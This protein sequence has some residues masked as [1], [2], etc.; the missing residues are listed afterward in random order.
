MI[1]RPVYALV[2]VALAALPIQAAAQRNLTTRLLE[3]SQ[4]YEV[5]GVQAWAVARANGFTFRPVPN[6]QGQSVAKPHDGVNTRLIA[7]V[8]DQRLGGLRN[9]RA[10][11]AS[12]VGGNMSVS[13]PSWTATFE[14]FGSRTLAPGWS[15]Q[16]VELSGSYVWERRPADGSPDLSFRVK[17][18][19]AGASATAIIRTVTLRGPAG[20]DWQDAFVGRRLFTI[21]GIEAWAVAHRYGFEFHPKVFVSRVN[22]REIGGLNTRDGV[23]SVYTWSPR[24]FGSLWKPGCHK[25]PGIEGRC[26]IAQ[27]TGG[28][29]SMPPQDRENVPNE[30]TSEFVMFGAQ[31]LAPGWVVKDVRVTRGQMIHSPALGTDDLSFEVSLR[32]Y[33]TQSVSAHVRTI[34]LEGPSDATSWEEA[35][36]VR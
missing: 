23:R 1:A 13:R 21:N 22:G 16:E 27:V 26:L 9:V 12:V 34:T 5:P 14:M 35:F 3:R 6:G 8:P 15:V 29:M 28:V 33:Q 20:K 4:D 18:S 19:S 11:V 31:R 10:T 32:A 17:L 7:S 24:D 36:R 2:T 30:W 25:V